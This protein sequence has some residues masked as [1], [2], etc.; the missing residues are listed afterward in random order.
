[1]SFVIGCEKVG[2]MEDKGIKEGPDEK[3]KHYESTSED[4]DA[5]LEQ[6]EAILSKI[7]DLKFI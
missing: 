5:Q 7:L 3:V 1:M 6:P 2:N 4:S